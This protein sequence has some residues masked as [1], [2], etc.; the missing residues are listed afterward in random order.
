MKDLTLGQRILE[1][2]GKTSRKVFCDEMEIG[3][4][5]LQ[6]YESDERSPDLDF[7]I[8]LQNKTGLSLDYLV[9]GEEIQLNTDEALVIEKYRNVD[10][11][12]KNKVLLTLMG[13]DMSFNSNIQ[14]SV[15]NSFNQS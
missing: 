8:K 9:H 1:I 4:A 11:Q 13:S 2:R 6:R 7:L 12:T 14:N 15:V 10:E 3:T 5:T